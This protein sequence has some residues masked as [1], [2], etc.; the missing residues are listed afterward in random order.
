MNGCRSQHWL[1]GNIDGSYGS[2]RAEERF[3]LEVLAYTSDIEILSCIAV[4]RPAPPRLA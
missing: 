4:I 1:D 2:R 3:G